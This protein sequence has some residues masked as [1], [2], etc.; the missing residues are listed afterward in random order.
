MNS[1][2]KLDVGEFVSV[3]CEE[4]GYRY[5][6]KIEEVDQASGKLLIHWHGFGA[7]MNFWLK[8]S[9]SRIGALEK[10]NVLPPA[11]TRSR[12]ISTAGIPMDNNS[13]ESSSIANS[14][15]ITEVEGSCCAACKTQ[16]EEV[17]LK[18][19]H[20]PAQ[21]HL[22]CSDLPQ[23]IMVRFLSTESGYICRCCVQGKLS[24]LDMQKTT[25]KISVTVQNEK[26]K[27][28]KLITD[29]VSKSEISH[30]PFK[31][32]EKKSEKN[33]NSVV[34]NKYR[35]GNCPHGLKGNKWIDGEKCKFDHPKICFRFLKAGNDKKYG[36][37][38]G[39]ECEWFHPYL[40]NAANSR[41]K[42]CFKKRCTYLHVRG[43][44]RVEKN[45][46]ERSSDIQQVQ[47]V[48]GDVYSG[49]KPSQH[50]KS[51]SNASSTETS[52]ILPKNDQLERIEQMIRSMKETYDEELKSLKRELVLSRGHQSPWMGP[53]YQ[54][55]FP[56]LGSPSHAMG[57]Q[58][59]ARGP[60]VY[61]PNVQPSSL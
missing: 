1:E 60:A 2:L 26:D 53:Q 21:V 38:K 15:D 57:M 49:G 13:A 42:V 28:T 30:V 35:H 9:S 3:L 19:D 45:K 22:S 5:E 34:C 54:W 31:E 61:S 17:R 25:E 51:F 20:C 7:R 23:Y 39:K 32:D 4:D 16:L 59:Q 55:M 46:S 52:T 12:R 10:A 24:P 6:C 58:Q 29:P 8:R 44:K 14:T 37:K 43:V 50:K 27:I 36:C 18:C 41:D 47:R 48:D 33:M 40:C 56:P 11:P